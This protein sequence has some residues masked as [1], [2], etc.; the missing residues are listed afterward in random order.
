[1]Q[2]SA[3][4]VSSFAPSPATRPAVAGPAPVD[5]TKLAV[6]QDNVKM[7]VSAGAALG[8]VNAELSGVLVN[9]SA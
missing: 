2:I 8:Q 5:L 3:A 7:A 1:V 6:A 9:I 4:K